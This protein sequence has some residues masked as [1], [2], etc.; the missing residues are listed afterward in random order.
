MECSLFWNV[1]VNAWVCRKSMV[2]NLGNR[3]SNF[4][5][6]K[7]DCIE[8]RQVGVCLVALLFLKAENISIGRQTFGGACW[9]PRLGLDAACCTHS[10]QPGPQTR[11][12]LCADKHFAKR[13][14]LSRSWA[15]G[16]RVPPWNQRDQTL[17]P[18]HSKAQVSSGPCMLLGWQAHCSLELR[19]SLYL[20]L[21]KRFFFFK[22]LWKGRGVVWLNLDLDTLLFT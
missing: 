14:Q 17:L 9:L 12:E 15:S 20:I 22:L 8:Y 16:F 1:K 11:P 6:S 19:E 10:P 21:E 13:S 2:L 5:V 7:L 4:H 3:S 18:E